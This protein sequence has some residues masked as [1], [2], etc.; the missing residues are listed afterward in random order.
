[1]TA[2]VSLATLASSPEPD[3]ASW[4][5][6]DPTVDAAN[7][8]ATHTGLTRSEDESSNP[9]EALPSTLLEGGS[10]TGA[11]DKL[12]KVPVDKTMTLQLTWMLRDESP[13]REVHGVAR[14]HK[15]AAG[16]N[17]EGG[18]VDEMSHM[19]N[20]RERKAKTSMD[21]TAA[22]MIANMSES[23]YAST[24]SQPSMPLKQRDGQAMTSDAGAGMHQPNGA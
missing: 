3:M 12:G 4:Q 20:D 15:E 18:E 11:S 14:S 21:M 16:V 5:V 19:M 6:V 22:T 2:G 24:L 7:P 10:W 8:N 23:M 1:M 9:P 17:I 13:S